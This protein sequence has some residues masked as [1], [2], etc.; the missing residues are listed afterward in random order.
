[1]T[2]VER[3]WNKVQ[4]SDGCWEWTGATDGYGYGQI[5][6]NGGERRAHRLSWEFSTG[7]QPGNLDVCHRCD[8]PLCVNPEHLF[9]GTAKD[10]CADMMRK[11][12]QSHFPR[13]RGAK[14]NRSKLTE[15]NV[16]NI[17]EM[18]DMGLHQNEIAKTFGVTRSAVYAIRVGNT[19]AYLR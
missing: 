14:N 4:K 8:N 12:R 11:G 17:R 10:N 7:D 6:N 5:W 18:L 15:S 19:W 13:S 3:F 2:L 16:H 1:M 9:L